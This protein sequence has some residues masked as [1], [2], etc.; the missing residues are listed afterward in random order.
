MQYCLKL[1][2]KA[3]LLDLVGSVVD[4]EK[5]VW[6]LYTVLVYFHPVIAREA[7]RMLIVH[8]PHLLV[9]T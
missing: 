9:E 6:V 7:L 3:A 5:T 2:A 4:I 8:G 1:L